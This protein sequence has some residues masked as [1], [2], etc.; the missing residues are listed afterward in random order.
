MGNGTVRILILLA[1][2]LA[3]AGLPSAT[4]V[5]AGNGAQASTVAVASVDLTPGRTIPPSFLGLSL[6]YRTVPIFTGTP[7]NGSN[8]V[9]NQLLANLTDNGGGPISLRIGGNSEDESWWNPIGA[10]QPAGV[11]YDVTPD[12]MAGLAA[13]AAQTGSPLI[14]G[15][16]LGQ[17][18]PQV[19]VDLAQ[20]SL[21]ALPDG[22]IA[23]F[24]IG[25]EP[26]LYATHAIPSAGSGGPK[27]VRSGDWSYEAYQ[28]QFS[29]YAGALATYLPRPVALAGPA[30]AGTKWL[31]DLPAFVAAESPA[32]GVVTQHVYPL[33]SCNK[34]PDDPRYPTIQQ[35]LADQSSH[36]L[37]LQLAPAI[38]TAHEAGQPIRI[39]EMNSIACG[40]ARG[41]SDSTASALWA[42]D[43]LFELASAG[44]DGVNFHHSQSQ[45]TN[46]GAS[47]NAFTFA[48]AANGFA[49]HVNP[50]YYA[51]LL[52]SQA[53]GNDARL[54][55]VSVQSEQNV[56]VWATRNGSGQI[57]LVALNK[58]EHQPV[59]LQVALPGIS[60]SATLARLSSAGAAATTGLN[61]SGQSFDGSTD[62][63]PVGNRSAS[64]V[65][66]SD[67]YYSFDLPAAG[68][69]LF[70]VDAPVHSQRLSP[71]ISATA[72]ASD[73]R[74]C[75]LL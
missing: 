8:T 6:E 37:A 22:S 66:R 75:S 17:G 1:L 20:A 54:L 12:W 57:N 11:S 10:M 42:V 34:Q 29:D 64:Q 39:A 15:L 60:Q 53:A 68:A 7:A 31:P 43:A 65:M 69:A 5:H 32:L 51:L 70:T 63:R 49:P 50:L 47:Y 38:A 62:G 58:D 71:I 41:V 30:F 27:L 61:L 40:G 4:H 33:N 72:S 59:R 45:S 56:K 55:P 46:G 67:G 14:L 52:F 73:S 3:F 74:S 25:N 13:S 18:D 44:A 28:A 35:L 36:G 9:F 21:A 23:A 24:E 48:G 26:D 16:N 2:I 19:V